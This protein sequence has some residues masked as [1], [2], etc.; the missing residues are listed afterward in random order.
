MIQFLVGTD[1]VFTWQCVVIKI[2]ETII[3][4]NYYSLKSIV[5][6]PQ[7][8]N[9]QNNCVPWTSHISAWLYTH[10]P[11]FT[12]RKL[13]GTVMIALECSSDC[14]TRKFMNRWVYVCT[15]SFSPHYDSEHVGRFVIAHSFSPD[16]TTRKLVGQFMISCTLWLALLVRTVRRKFVGALWSPACTTRETRQAL[17]VNAHFDGNSSTLYRV[18]FRLSNSESRRAFDD[19]RLTRQTV[20][21]EET[22]RGFMMANMKWS[23]NHKTRLPFTT[24]LGNSLGIR[25]CSWFT[26][27]RTRKLVGIWLLQFTRAVRLGKNLFLHSRYGPCFESTLA[28]PTTWHVFPSCLGAFQVN[29]CS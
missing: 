27:F 14:T 23:S 6:F 2:I 25:N 28:P 1:W 3:Y 5:H 13:V 12:T 8:W 11:D 7:E 15:D 16:C 19:S 20:R 9:L 21:L 10:F 17:H 24:L 29:P 22:H 4:F 18:I 26:D